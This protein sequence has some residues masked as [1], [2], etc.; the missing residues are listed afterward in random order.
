MSSKDYTRAIKLLNLALHFPKNPAELIYIVN[1]SLA[2]AYFETKQ[3]IRAVEKGRE[4]LKSKPTKSQVCYNFTSRPTNYFYVQ[5]GHAVNC[6]LL[7]LGLY[8]FIRG[9]RRGYK[10]RGLCHRRLITRIGKVLQNK[11]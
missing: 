5:K 10:Q 2:T 1:N 8:I 11:L 7:A 4:C 6:R 3:Y 9:F